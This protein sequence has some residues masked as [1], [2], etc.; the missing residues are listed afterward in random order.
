LTPWLAH[1]YTGLGAVVA[2]AATIEVVAGDFRGAFLW[3][4]VQL[5]IDSTDGV[6]ARALRVKDRLPHFDGARLDDIIDYLTYVFIPVLLMLQAGLLPAGWSVGVGGLVLLASGYG[7][8]RSDAK[9]LTSDYFFTGFP[10]YW[11]LVA[12][13]LFL[14]DLSPAINAGVVTLLALLV[15]VPTRYI[16]PSRTKTLSRLTLV[17]GMLW[18]ALLIWIVWRLPATDGP[19]A[20]ISLVFPVYYLALSFWLDWQSRRSPAAVAAGRAS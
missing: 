14:F 19:W 9:T 1:F 18:G 12:L 17:L 16:Y 15:F 13:Y 4:G 7:F 20:A 8:C 2:L 11:N 3:L 10:S 5:L 6:L